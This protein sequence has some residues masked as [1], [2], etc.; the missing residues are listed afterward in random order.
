MFLLLLLMLCIFFFFLTFFFLN[1]KFSLESLVPDILMVSVSDK[2]IAENQLHI[3]NKIGEG[4]FAD[5]FRGYFGDIHG[6]KGRGEGGGGGGE[7]ERKDTKNIYFSL[8]PLTSFPPPLSSLFFSFFFSC[9]Q[10][11]EI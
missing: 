11:V 1:R 3:E 2:A 8:T 4:G 10:K 6:M 7:P 9:Y 5:V